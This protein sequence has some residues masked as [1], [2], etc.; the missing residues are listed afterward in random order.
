MTKKR[1][2]R[3]P[4]AFRL[5]GAGADEKLR[6]VSELA[7]ELRE[8]G[9]AVGEPADNFSNLKHLSRCHLGLQHALDQSE[10]RSLPNVFS[11]GNCDLASHS[12]K[13]SSRRNHIF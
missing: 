1:V 7:W 2:N 6:H 12:C 11:G 9:S 5:M 10:M 13:I 3:Y 4:K 8:H